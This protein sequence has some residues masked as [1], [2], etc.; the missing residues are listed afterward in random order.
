[1]KNLAQSIILGRVPRET[2]S[3]LLH[4]MFCNI[5]QSFSNNKLGKWLKIS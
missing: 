4:I 2:F 1:M 3:M 5:V